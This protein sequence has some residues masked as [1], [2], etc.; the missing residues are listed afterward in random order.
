MCLSRKLHCS[1]DWEE[2]KIQLRNNSAVRYD[3]FKIV[4]SKRHIELP[5]LP[6][7]HRTSKTTT[8]LMIGS[9]SLND[10]ERKCH[11]YHGIVNTHLCFICV[12]QIHVVEAIKPMNHIKKHIECTLKQM[13]IVNILWYNY[14][15]YFVCWPFFLHCSEIKF[16][17]NLLHEKNK[18]LIVVVP[19]GSGLE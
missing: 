19:W 10:F 15:C 14:L 9:E 12:Y 6:V 7:L 5:S 17:H 18:S 1:K 2:F 3:L 8:A 13:C 11:C 4:I 16:I